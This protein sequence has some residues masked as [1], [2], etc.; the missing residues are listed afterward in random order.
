MQTVPLRSALD[1]P[2]YGR[3]TFTQTRL[4]AAESPS[5]QIEPMT[6]LVIFLLGWVGASVIPLGE[7]GRSAKG[8]IVAKLK[9]ER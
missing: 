9:R 1:W 4:Q 6:A 5:L 7:I 3:S 2:L 8:G